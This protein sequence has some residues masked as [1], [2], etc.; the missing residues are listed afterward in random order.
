MQNIVLK[1]IAFA[2]N[3]HADQKDRARQ[4]YVLHCL[5]VLDAV[6]S[7]TKSED[8]QCAAVLHDVMEDCGI[9]KADLIAQGFSQRTVNLVELMTREDRIEYREYI[10]SIYESNDNAAMM[11]KLADLADNL[12]PIRLDKLP[13]EIKKKLKDKYTWAVEYL[14][15]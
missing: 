10:T 14:L 12:D 5:R 1:A 7:K 4:S 11:I 9:T 3:A 13:P 2:I 8:V 6:K 15:D